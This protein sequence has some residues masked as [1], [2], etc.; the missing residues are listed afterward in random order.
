MIAIRTRMFIAVS[1][2]ALV[3]CTVGPDYRRP[4]L[5][6]GA[7]APMVSIDKKAEASIAVPDD[8]WRLYQDPKLTD[9]LEE[10]FNA[11]YDIKAAEANLSASRAVLDASRAGL[12]PSTN[13]NVGAIRGRNAT[14][15][16]I[17]EIGGHEPKTTWSYDAILDVSYEIDLFG[18]V[19]RAVEASQADTQGVQA[20]RDAVK[21]TVAAE[22]ARAYGQICSL[23]EQIQVAQHSVDVV[24][25]EADIV[26]RRMLA[27]AGSEFEFV[28]ASGLI[29]QVRATVAPLEGQRQA[30]LFQLAALLGRT[31]ANA[32]LETLECSAPPRL[33][34]LIPVG[35]G[36]ALLR[37][38]P[39]IRQAE[40]RVAADTARVGV[41]TADLYP[42]ISLLGSVGGV[43]G[44]LS[45]L[46]AAR[47][48][49]W[50]LGPSISW[51]FPNQTLYRARVKQ[52]GALA[53][54]SLAYFDSTVLQALKETEQALATYNAEL[55][56][57]E[58]LNDAQRL[59][60]REFALA[61]EQF[62][63][64]AVSSLDMLTS[65]QSMVASD[66][67]VAASDA[68]TLQAQIQLFKSLGGGW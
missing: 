42:R 24:T 18:H 28:R 37:R 32:P 19:R 22:T 40:R 27:G 65:E 45:A 60:H 39:D 49:T 63:Y 35:D 29:A 64:G 10:A 7:D 59:A 15:D 41:A 8:W 61:K 66:A 67:A 62:S 4:T 17:L 12:Y 44:Q 6:A 55:T 23:G 1:A 58:S 46:T 47:G 56:Q 68:R 51:T 25:H 16:Q 54:Q 14:T 26:H 34:T 30:A 5:P 11:N 31:P 20:A 36:V 2:T 9:L 13:A 21:I 53:D 50:G 57:R 48:L 33:L 52:A 43:G 3:A 38:R